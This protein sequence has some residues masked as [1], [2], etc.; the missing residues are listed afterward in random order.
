M[1]LLAGGASPDA[2]RRV[3]NLTGHTIYSVSVNCNTP[4]VV[5]LTKIQQMLES[6]R[7]APLLR[8][9][10]AFRCARTPQKNRVSG[11]VV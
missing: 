9:M 11:R 6:A 10:A 5:L 4:W 7:A 2:A 8:A 1:V 3:V